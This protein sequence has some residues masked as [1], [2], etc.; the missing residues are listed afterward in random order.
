MALVITPFR[1]L[2]AAERAELAEEGI[3]LLRFMAP[4]TQGVDVIIRSG[5]GDGRAADS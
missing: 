4:T 3:G 2:S 5:E 1:T